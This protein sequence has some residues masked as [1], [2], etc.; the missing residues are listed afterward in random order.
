M[1]TVL[2]TTQGP[3]CQCKEITPFVVMCD[4]ELIRSEK[5][6][7]LFLEHFKEI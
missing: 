3:N 6:I 4:S 1:C 5:D 2:E 7:C